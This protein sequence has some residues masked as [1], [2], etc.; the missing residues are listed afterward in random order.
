MSA[1]WEYLITLYHCGVRGI[2]PPEPPEDMDWEAFTQLADRQAVTPV[3][4]SALR[5]TRS[6][7]ADLRQSIH[8]AA[9]ELSLQNRSR[10]EAALD[11]LQQLRAAGITAAVLKGM[12]LARCYDAPDTRI[13]ADTDI[14]IAPA[15]EDAAVAFFEQH[16]CYVRRRSK[17][18]HHFTALHSEAGLFEIHVRLWDDEAAL[19]FGSWD[20]TLDDAVSLP[21][22]ALYGRPFFVLPETDAL[23]HLCLH[24]IKHFVQRQEGL[25]TAYD[26][27]LFF[28][29]NR[30]RIQH[31]ALWEDLR[32]W[33]AD[34]IYNTVL[35]VF[36]RAGCFSAEDFP[37][38]TLQDAAVCDLLS[39]DMEQFSRDVPMH[40]YAGSDTWISYARVRA[41]AQGGDVQ[42]SYK[43]RRRELRR[44]VLLPSIEEMS[45][46]YP[47]LKK[48]RLL[49][50][51]FWLHRGVTGVFSRKRR[52]A[53]RRLQASQKR[54]A[55]VKA[56]PGS[57]AALMQELGLFGE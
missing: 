5:K 50:P 28:A 52:D 6:C 18:Q 15:Q 13:C 56:K 43:K 57:R 10:Q 25:R 45:V 14:L 24:L 49:Y 32:R 11:I 51:F 46:R 47:S 21:E 12:S 26:T 4:F 53:I 27:A 44:S 33:N 16:G 40:F 8:M 55:A 9:L 29:E 41:A 38:M 36:V 3:V 30:A 34:V 1:H 48:C 54:P 2:A 22:T 35:S 17:E 31:E 42:E 20:Y 23:R 37:G 7:P 39:A 19:A